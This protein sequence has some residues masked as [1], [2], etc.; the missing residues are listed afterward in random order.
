MLMMRF[1]IRTEPRLA[2]ILPLIQFIFVVSLILL[3]FVVIV[4][5]DQPEMM[6]TECVLR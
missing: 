2:F 5:A 3:P 1:Q 6:Q 4:S